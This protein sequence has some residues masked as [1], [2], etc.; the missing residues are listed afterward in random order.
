MATKR[1]VT[2]SLDDDL[3][4]ELESR[5]DLSVQ[6]NEAA[7]ILLQHRRRGGRL[8]ALLDQFDRTDGPLVDDPEEDAR[9]ERLIGGAG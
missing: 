3:T 6:L 5:G 9:I 8:T 2:V 1:T 4:R 7:R